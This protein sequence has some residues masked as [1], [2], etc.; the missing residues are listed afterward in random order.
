[1]EGQAAVAAESDATAIQPCGVVGEEAVVEVT[2]R[3]VGGK[4]TAA[5]AR[6]CDV[7]GKLKPGAVE[8]ATGIGSSAAAGAEHPVID[9]QHI[10]RAGKHEHIGE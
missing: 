1:M 7:G 5:C 8:L 10:Q 3:G 9:L 4:D 6:R 2:A